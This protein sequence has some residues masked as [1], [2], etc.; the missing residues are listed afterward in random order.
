MPSTPIKKFDK[1][2]VVFRE[3]DLGEEMYIIHRGRVRIV[4][5]MSSK[6]ETLGVLERGDFFG[7][8]AII[9]NLRRTATVIAIEDN[10]ELIAI[11]KAQFEDMLKNQI[12]IAIRMI[13]KYAHR[14][15]ESN[16]RVEKMIRDKQEIDT[17]IQDILS[18]IR[19]RSDDREE[20]S[21]IFGWLQ[22]NASSSSFPLKRPEVLVGRQDSVTRIHPDIDLTS[23]DDNRTVS[24]RHARI[25]CMED[26]VYVSEEIGATNGTLLN[27]RQID[28]GKIVLIK[29][30]D[31]LNFGELGFT[32]VL[33]AESSEE[34]K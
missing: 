33:N 30:N 23:I 19:K 8:M 12:E 22:H 21:E 25:S 10:T 15:R 32:V 14:L 7:E 24:R 1:D 26:G 28:K 27:S 34:N 31:Q 20:G 6:F 11:N 5:Q 2:S 13:R 16:E 9:D 3:G 18:H 4:K 29:H 17:G